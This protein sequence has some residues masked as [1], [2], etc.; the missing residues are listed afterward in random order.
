M[1]ILYLD[2]E[3]LPA[4]EKSFEKLKFLYGRKLEKKA[5]KKDISEEIVIE[6]GDSNF[7]SYI[8]N[9]SFDG[10]FGRLLCI[11]VALNNEDPDCYFDENDEKKTLEQFW[12][13]AGRCDLFVGHNVMDF[14]LRF[15]WQRS[16]VLGI[17]PTWQ[18]TD[19]GRLKYITFA[20]YRRFPIFDTM[21]EWAKWGWSKDGSVGL[22]HLAL[23]LDIPT[24]KNAIDGSKVF[25]FYKAR[26]IKE[27]CD[28][29]KRDVETV[30]AIYKKMNFQ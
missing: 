8:K 3:T 29:C 7:E 23:S 19:Q 9:T 27:I 14:D 15:L 12:E 11:G 5:K 18:D 21:H 17:K 4:D 22:E 28:Y 10:G 30:R 1:N 20:K 25:D 13:I 16:I 6:D 2:I 26:K 24:P